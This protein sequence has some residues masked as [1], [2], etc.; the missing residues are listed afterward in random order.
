MYHNPF[1]GLNFVSVGST[2][3]DLISIS[4]S[5]GHQLFRC[6]K[7]RNWAV[8][9]PRHCISHSYMGI[10]NFCGQN[11]GIGSIIPMAKER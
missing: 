5:I 4:V 2:T 8:I 7:G 6:T 9:M 3:F 11:L 10:V 1:V